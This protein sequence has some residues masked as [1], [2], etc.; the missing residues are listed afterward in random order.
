MDYEEYC[1]FIKWSNALPRERLIDCRLFGWYREYER[2][3]FINQGHCPDNNEVPHDVASCESCDDCNDCWYK[4]FKWWD[5]HHRCKV[6]WEV[7]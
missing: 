1:E 2:N 7:N 5:E 6:F 4:T 3:G